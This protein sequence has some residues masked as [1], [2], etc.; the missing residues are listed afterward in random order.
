MR[1]RIFILLILFMIPIFDTEAKKN[2]HEYETKW[3]AAL[4][5]ENRLTMEM[6]RDY[7]GNHIYENDTLVYTETPVGFIK[8]DTIYAYVKDYR[9]NVR[10]VI[11]EF[12]NVAET[13]LFYP[14]GGLMTDDTQPSVSVQMRKFEGKEFDR[15]Y[16]QNVYDYHARMYDP[17]LCGFNSQDPQAEKYPDISPYAFCAANPNRFIDPTGEDLYELL[18][19]GQIELREKNKDIYDYIYSKTHKNAITVEKD[20][21]NSKVEEPIAIQSSIYGL[22][23][24]TVTVYTT[25]NNNS[26]N[27]FSFIIQNSDVEWSYIITNSNNYIGTTHFEDL[28][29]SGHYIIDNI[30]SMKESVIEANHNH[31]NGWMVVSGGDVEFAKKTE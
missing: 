2:L 26:N 11:D 6:S 12:G 14:Y 10:S 13:N 9:G 20:F 18:P 4:K 24:G 17:Y 21:I 22:I 8:N 3:T 15:E 23:T 28:D 1:L 29:S 27:I 16:G 25:N 31:P 5:N 30:I 7:L 19:N